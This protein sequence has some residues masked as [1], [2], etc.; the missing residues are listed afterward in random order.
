M[1]RWLWPALLGLTLLA[2]AGPTTT[3]APASRP[4]H[5]VRSV[6][7]TPRDWQQ[8]DSIV[9]AYKVAAEL[10]DCISLPDPLEWWSAK[11]K[12]FA[13]SKAGQESVWQKALLAGKRC[14]ILVQLDPYG[15]PRTGKLAAKLPPELKGQTFASPGVR[16]AFI[17]EALART[18]AYDAKYVC[19]GMEVNAYYEQQPDDF[20]NFVSLFAE[21]RAAIKQR[22]PDTIVFVSF[23]YE[24]L[25]GRFGGQAG[26]TVHPPHWELLAKFEPHTDAIGLSSYPWASFNPIRFGAPEDLPEDYY[27]QI[28]QHTRKPIIFA[29]LGWSTDP[30]YG[31][32]EA[33]QARFLR[34]FDQLTRG[35][36]VQLVNYFFLYDC[37]LFGPVF[38]SMGLYDKTGRP[39]EACAVWQHLWTEP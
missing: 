38:A 14:D 2:G 16:Q 18:E 25:L 13:A 33:A 9:D 7:P 37:T 6:V 15:S 29:E 11:G 35:L 39:K 8:R 30:K 17:A 26:M 36:N 5:V 20:D 3:R 21:A 23:Q 10:N 27:A 22:R 1:H 34:R 19:L 12:T 31:G 4:A 32:S 24:Q 28:A